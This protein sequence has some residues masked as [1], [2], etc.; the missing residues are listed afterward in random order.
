[1]RSCKAVKLSSYIDDNIAVQRSIVSFLNEETPLSTDARNEVMRCMSCFGCLDVKCPID[2]SSMT[3]NELVKR[4][5]EEISIKPTKEE[6]FSTQS[7]QSKRLTSPDQYNRISS[8]AESDSDIL[9]FPGC[10]IYSQPDKLLNALTILDQIGNPYDFIPGINYCCGFQRGCSGD[11]EWFDAEAKNLLT[12]IETMQVKTVILWCPSCLC[13]FENYFSKVFKPNMKWISF[14]EYV[15]DNINKLSFPYSKSRKVT[16]HEPFKTAYMGLNTHVRDIL[17][18][19]P[20]TE[21]IEMEHHGHE[22]IC[23]GCDADINESGFGNT[24]AL[25]RLSEAASTGCETLAVR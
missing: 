25:K 4:E 9:F 16:Y 23:C 14:G 22:T 11:A 2:V 3:I 20:G 17:K 1:M 8:L 12:Q 10:N 5:L 15:Y 18:S 24:V 6:I 19:I 7:K 13:V 21:L